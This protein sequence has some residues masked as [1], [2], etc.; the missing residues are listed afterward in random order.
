MVFIFVKCS[1]WKGTLTGSA[2]WLGCGDQ[3]GSQSYAIWQ[4]LHE[5]LKGTKAK[6]RSSKPALRKFSGV[7]VTSLHGRLLVNSL[8]QKLVPAPGS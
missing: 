7:P 3:R 4:Q 2:A 6:P 8:F 5:G 1:L